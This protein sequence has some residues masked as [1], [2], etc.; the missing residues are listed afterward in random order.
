MTTILH[1]TTE[2]VCPSA[3]ADGAA[4]WLSAPD[5]ERATGW[6]LKPEG[7]CRDALCIPIPPPLRSTLVK[8]EAIDAAGLWSSLGNPVAHDEGNAV[9]L[10]GT[11]S[12]QRSAALETL[13]A[14]D[15]ALPD[16][17]GVSHRLVDYRGRKVLVVSWA[18]W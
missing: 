15:F 17:A 11:G 8:N 3:R 12:G 7:L 16:L 5:L 14:P 13:E 10:L 9:W 1:E 2:T 18:S 6:A 4:L